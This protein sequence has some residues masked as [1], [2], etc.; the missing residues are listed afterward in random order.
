M[1]LL[2][3][4]EIAASLSV[5]WA[6]LGLEEGAR[7]SVRDVGNRRGLPDAVGRF[8]ARVGKHDVAFVRLTPR[9]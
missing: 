6:E 8:S 9:K 4:D 3:R 2:N 5:T 1:V 7:M